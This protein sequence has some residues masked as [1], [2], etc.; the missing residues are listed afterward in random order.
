MVPQTHGFCCLNVKLSSV[1]VAGLDLQPSLIGERAMELLV[2]Q[3]Y[4][5]K[6]GIPETASNTTIP[7]AW[8]D[9]PTVRSMGSVAN[10]DAPL[11]EGIH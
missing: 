11:N 6:Y 8:V 4:S 2:S 3:I 1:P 10:P 9:G 5:N 7:S